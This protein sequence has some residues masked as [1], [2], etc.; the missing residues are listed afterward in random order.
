MSPIGALFLT[1]VEFD[2]RGLI[3]LKTARVLDRM[4]GDSRWWC[5]RLLSMSHPT[6]WGFYVA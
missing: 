3:T 1:V 2:A 6:L 5:E 4:S